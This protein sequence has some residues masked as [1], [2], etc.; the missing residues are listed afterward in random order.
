M[1]AFL[2][3]IGGLAALLLL[4]LPAAADP[5]TGIWVDVQPWT[6]AKEL[7]PFGRHVQLACDALGGSCEVVATEKQ[8]AFRAALACGEGDAAAGN[9]EGLHEARL[10]AFGV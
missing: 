2:P 10:K 9:S 7:G 4:S 3:W 6:C 8:A 5:V 1:Q